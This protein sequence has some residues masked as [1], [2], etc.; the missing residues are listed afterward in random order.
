MPKDN[1]FNVQEGTTAKRC[2]EKFEA[3]EREA[4]RP[5]TQEASNA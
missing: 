1:P 3:V 4:K 2:R 5:K